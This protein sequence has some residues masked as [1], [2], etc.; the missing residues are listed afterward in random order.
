[1]QV[2]SE[3]IDSGEVSLSDVAE[4]SDANSADVAGPSGHQ[5][6]ADSDDGEEEVGDLSWE[7]VMAAVQGGGSEDDA[8]EEQEQKHG[9]LSRSNHDDPVKAAPQSLPK[10]QPRRQ[11]G[12]KKGKK[13]A[14]N[15]SQL[16]K[17]PRQQ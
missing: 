5:G 11:S 9:G 17:R 8:E 12:A 4:D 13:Q 1:M 2:G 16:G 7:A 14:Q 10:A 6:V 3:D 15:G